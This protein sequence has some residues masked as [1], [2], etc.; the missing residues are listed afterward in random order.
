MLKD[1]FMRDYC[2]KNRYD[3]RIRQQRG[4]ATSD[5]VI[6]TAV[7]VRVFEVTEIKPLSRINCRRICMKTTGIERI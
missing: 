6:I 2:K 3:D 1:K 5:I 4:N 7:T